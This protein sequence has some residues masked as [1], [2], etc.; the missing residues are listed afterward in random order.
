M[1]RIYSKI[2]NLL[3]ETAPPM[4][5]HPDMR[6]QCRTPYHPTLAL[7]LSKTEKKVQIL[8]A[9]TQTNNPIRIPTPTLAVTTHL[10]PAESISATPKITTKGI[11]AGRLLLL[12]YQGNINNITPTTTLT[13]ATTATAPQLQLQ[14]PQNHPINAQ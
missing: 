5:S 13:T 12:L 4:T 2:I 14:H 3:R 7:T 10:C 11:T 8:L 1:S 6:T 9:A